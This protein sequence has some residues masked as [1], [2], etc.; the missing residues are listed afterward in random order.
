MMFERY[1][2]KHIFYLSLQ[3]RVCFV[4]CSL[5]GKFDLKVWIGEIFIKMNVAEKQVG[6]TVVCFCSNRQMTCV[7]KCHHCWTSYI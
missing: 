5:F 1:L 6:M 7:V 3:K 2:I 4:I